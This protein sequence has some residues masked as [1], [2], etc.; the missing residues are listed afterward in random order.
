MRVEI[1]RGG[2]FDFG[3]IGTVKV[4]LGSGTVKHRG[5]AGAVVG[6]VVLELVGW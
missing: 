2:G 6:A 5:E 4:V 1:F 3:A